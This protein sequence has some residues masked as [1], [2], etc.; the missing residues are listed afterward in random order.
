MS[1]EITAVIP[2][3]K[4]SSRLPNKN[5]L[6]FNETTLLEHK[7][8]QLKKTQGVTRII[9]SSDSEYMLSLAQKHGVET[10][11]RP[12]HFANESKPFSDFLEYITS[13]ISTPN[14]LWSCCTSPLVDE[15]LYS[16]AI[17][18]YFWCLENNYDSLI[19]TYDFKHFLLDEN[20]TLNFERGPK[21]VNSEDL[22]KLDL[23]TN[24]AILAPL[25]S[26]TLWKYHFG[27]NHYRFP[28]TQA[29]SID[30]DTPT[31]YLVAKALW[32][33]VMEK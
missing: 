9:V 17:E 31:D 20:G 19:T 21:H 27:P 15:N 29:E 16:K 33:E 7:I 4:N 30:I 24:G 25:K 1:N 23:F 26:M 8:I 28:V 14:M 13:K 18:K 5:I 2:V 11:L 22:P 3:K 32:A 6:P 12:I 10:D